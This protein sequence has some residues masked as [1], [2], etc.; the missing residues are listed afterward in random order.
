LERGPSDSEQHWDEKHALAHVARC[1]VCE[2]LVSSLGA[3]IRVSTYLTMH[4][5]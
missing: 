1:P 2:A 4:R 5:Q 3:E